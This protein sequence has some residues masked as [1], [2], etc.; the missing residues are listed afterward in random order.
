MTSRSS[1]IFELTGDVTDF[2]AK[3]FG[4][5]PFTSTGAI[6]DNVPNVGFSLETQTRPLY[7]FA[8]GAGHGVARAGAP[9]VR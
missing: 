4:P 7:G 2:W 3:E 9:V 6:I 5:Y 1:R 8:A